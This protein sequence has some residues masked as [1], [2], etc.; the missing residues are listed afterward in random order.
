MCR[1]CDI[2]K[3]KWRLKASVRITVAYLERHATTISGRPRGH[4]VDRKV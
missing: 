4:G 1:A 2:D 3:L